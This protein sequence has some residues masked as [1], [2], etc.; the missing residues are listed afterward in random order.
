[1]SRPW[2]FCSDSNSFNRLA[3]KQFKN[4]ILR[5]KV[6]VDHKAGFLGFGE[7]IYRSRRSIIE[8]AIDVRILSAL[9]LKI[10]HPNSTFALLASESTPVDEQRCL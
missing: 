5:D 6:A 1:L 4:I 8:A 9:Q 10:F 2:F 7:S 3:A